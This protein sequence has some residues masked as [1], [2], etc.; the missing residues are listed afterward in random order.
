MK[1]VYVLYSWLTW[2]LKGAVI[3]FYDIF[4]EGG[5]GWGAKVKQ[6]SREI[7]LQQISFPNYFG[8][9]LLLL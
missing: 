4:L 6:I 1:Y 7:K 5:G 8:P 9:G 2:L 3:N